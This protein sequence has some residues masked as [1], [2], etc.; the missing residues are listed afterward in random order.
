MT[1][2]P[3]L[4]VTASRDTPVPS[5][6]ATTVAPGITAADVSRSWPTSVAVVTCARTWIAHARTPTKAKTILKKTFLALS[7]LTSGLSERCRR[8][9]RR[10]A[11][12]WLRER[13]RY[14][15]VGGPDATFGAGPL[16]GGSRKQRDAPTMDPAVIQHLRRT[17]RSLAAAHYAR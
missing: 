13:R 3:L 17:S 2:S 6:V 16:N 5:C 7:M 1:N 8:F 10:R 9:R 14:E 11:P 4:S 15:A 12:D